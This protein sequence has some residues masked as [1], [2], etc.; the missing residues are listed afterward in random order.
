MC[1]FACGE[2]RVRTNCREWAAVHIQG[3]MEPFDLPSPDPW[4]VFEQWMGEAEQSEPNDPNAAALATASADGAPSVRM[5]LVKGAGERGVR[6]FTNEDSQ[7][8]QELLANPRAAIVLH[9]KSLRRQVR[10]QGEVS[11]LSR[12]ETDEYFHSRGRRSQIAA[13]ISHQ[14]QPVASREQMDREVQEYTATLGDAPVPLPP[15]WSGFLLSPRVVEFWVDGPDRL[16]DRMQF[17]RDGDGWRSQRL[18]P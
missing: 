6:F 5:V 1:I 15:R 8:G 17:Q 2:R 13:A 16:H 12:E 10:F 14:S 18:Y 11:V 7:K 4:Q 3:A 9:W